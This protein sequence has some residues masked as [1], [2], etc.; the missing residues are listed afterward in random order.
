M[1]LLKELFAAP[2][3]LY[4][5]TAGDAVDTR[6]S[7]IRKY[8]V[9][10]VALVSTALIVSGLVGLYFTYDESKAARLNLQREKAEAAASRDVGEH[11]AIDEA[12]PH[13][14]QL[15][16]GNVG[17]ALVERRGENHPKRPPESCCG[18]SIRWPVSPRANE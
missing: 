7:L 13:A 8:V 17:K 12:R 14:R 15:A 1:Q 10:F 6:R 18:A 3:R 9:Y 16:F 5:V 4:F 11:V 2:L